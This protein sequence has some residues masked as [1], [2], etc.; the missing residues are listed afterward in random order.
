MSTVEQTVFLRVENPQL[1]EQ[2][3]LPKFSLSASAATIGSGSADWRLHDATGSVS[4]IHAALQMID[5]RYSLVDL[6]GKTYIN[7][8]REPLGANV[9]VALNDGDRIGIG[10]YRIGV[11]I[12]EAAGHA[13]YGASHLREMSVDQLID[14]NRQD[15]NVLFSPLSN[16]FE[17]YDDNDRTRHAMQQ[18]EGP[19]QQGLDPLF[20][21]DEKTARPQH[22]DFITH[23]DV[24]RPSG[25]T[26]SID[27]A[28]TV[29]ESLSPY[30]QKA[31]ESPMTSEQTMQ[32]ASES[33]GYASNQVDHIV[34]APLLNSLGLQLEKIDTEQA[35]YLLN[36]IG[37]AL[38]A[39]INGLLALYHA[40]QQRSVDLSLLGRSYQLIEDNPLRLGVDYTETVKAM[41]SKDK[42]QVHLSAP[43][44][45]EES[46]KNIQKN[47][48]A[49][50]KAVQEA[51]M[52]VL[53]AFAPDT[54]EQRFSRYRQH[55]DADNGGDAWAW[56][57]YKHY[58]DELG[59]TRQNGL[60]KL[61]WEVF[62]QAY[63]RHMR[64]VTAG[65][66]R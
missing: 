20:H 65:N 52:H 46:F 49:L 2:G 57:M 25:H 55:H 39:A 32:A 56:Q 38:K 28:G 30:Q 33:A 61:F 62:E 34:S 35:H 45:I 24:E 23:S 36:E 63:D 19:G 12:G 31:G 15:H 40:E 53:K 37:A 26:Q 13:H 41:F 16:R 9:V 48:D 22:T 21:L 58:F 6:C 42:S 14:P 60:E 1:L 29:R 66:A 27:L 44:A 3:S 59:S 11:H 4:D 18:F 10:K 50:L 5:G 8:H 64:D 47:Q 17:H 51:L 7:N 43:F 54:L